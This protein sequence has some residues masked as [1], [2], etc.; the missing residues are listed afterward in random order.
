MKTKIIIAVIIIAAGYYGYTRYL[1]SKE[2]AAIHKIDKDI[3]IENEVHSIVGDSMRA[4]PNFYR[5]ESDTAWNNS[6]RAKIKANVEEK[7]KNW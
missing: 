7:Y 6:Q 3:M 5:E 4:N 2:K 1:D